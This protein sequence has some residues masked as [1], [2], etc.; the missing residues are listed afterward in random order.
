M[1]GEHR[2]GH[3]SRQVAHDH[4]NHPGDTPRPLFFGLAMALAEAR[5]GATDDRGDEVLE[6]GVLNGVHETRLLMEGLTVS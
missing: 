6:G 3:I 5:G 2:F 1:A 4:V